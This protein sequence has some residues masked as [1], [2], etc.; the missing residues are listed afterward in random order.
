MYADSAMALASEPRGTDLR[1]RERDL[2]TY[3]SWQGD[4]RGGGS[5]GRKGHQKEREI[6]TPY[7]YN[8]EKVIRITICCTLWRE[9]STKNV[10]ILQGAREALK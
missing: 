7:K 3:I 9:S 10:S 8:E 6:D 5:L 4:I 1:E 2:G